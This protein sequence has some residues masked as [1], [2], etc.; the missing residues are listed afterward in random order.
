MNNL[1]EVIAEPEN[2]ALAAHKAFRGNAH[3][4]GVKKFRQDF[5]H[6]V[7]KIREELLDGRIVTS[8]YHK[9]LV[10]EP[11]ERLICAA[12]IKQRILHHAVMNVC[13]CIF[14][15]NLIFDSYASRPG[16]GTHKAIVRVKDKIKDY[17]YYAKLDVRK[18]FDSVN[19]EVLKS[20]LRRMFK[21]VRLLEIFD[22]IIDSYGKDKGLPIGNL[23]SQY[24][25]NYYLSGLDHFM[26]EQVKTPMYVRY[27]DDVILMDNDYDK[28]KNM[29]RQYCE[30]SYE[31]L[32]LC[33]KPPIV[34]RTCHGIP[35]L[36]YKIFGHSIMMNGKGKRRYIKN[37]R[38]VDMLYKNAKISESEYS[39]RIISNLSYACFADS[40]KFRANLLG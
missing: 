1:F 31:K 11:K 9:F 25:A 7:Y 4:Y 8:D 17:K 38:L 3:I 23:T 14:D 35:F 37:L 2:L 10:Y 36:G 20:L 39:I 32:R 5:L 28:L 15:R 16:K 13:H 29:I 27:M 34:G 33:I 21:D 30:Y 6:N 22:D 19:H 24:F 18:F 26:K 40:A 12:P